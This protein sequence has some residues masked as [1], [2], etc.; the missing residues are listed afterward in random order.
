[1]RIAQALA[2]GILALTVLTSTSRAQDYKD[3]YTAAETGKPMPP[4]KALDTMLS[5]F[6]YELMAAAQSMPADKYSFAPAPSTFVAG[7][8]AKFTKV[9]TFAEQLTHILSANYYFYSKVNNSA[10]PD[11]AKSVD[12]LKSKD[13]IIA[14]L[15]QSFAYAHTQTATITVANAFNGIEGADGMHTPATVASFAVAHGYDHYGQL[16]EYLRMNGILPP[17][18]K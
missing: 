16:V 9:R 6:E 13:E 1:M 5:L 11:A 15:K 18:S 2:G 17:G 14:A 4:A 8:P 3:P 7:S 12:G 10:L